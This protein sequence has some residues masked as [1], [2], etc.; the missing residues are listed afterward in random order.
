ME[1]ACE[2]YHCRAVEELEE[3]YASCP[4][5]PYLVLE[6]DDKLWPHYYMCFEAY[7]D[8]LR[9]RHCIHAAQPQHEGQC[10]KECGEIEDFVTVAQVLWVSLTP[11][12]HPVNAIFP[13]SVHER[14]CRH[15]DRT[16]TQHFAVHVRMETAVTV[17]N[18]YFQLQQ[19]F[20]EM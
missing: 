15:G 16:R 20:Y 7:D 1:K 18:A 11:S 12:H 14:V 13:S 19:L 2:K 9:Y 4:D 3:C 6:N 17:S 10:E 8:F 5:H